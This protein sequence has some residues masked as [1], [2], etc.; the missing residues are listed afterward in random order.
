MASGGGTSRGRSCTL[1]ET[2]D[3]CLREETNAEGLSSSEES[4]LDHQ[5]YDMDE[6]QR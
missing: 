4:D 3:I 6:N 5:L 2:I 1:E